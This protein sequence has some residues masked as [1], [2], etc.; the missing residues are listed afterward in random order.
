MRIKTV[1]LNLPEIPAIPDSPEVSN[2]LFTAVIV[3]TDTLPSDKRPFEPLPD[4]SDDT[5]VPG[6]FSQALGEFKLFYEEL[7]PTK[8]ITRIKRVQV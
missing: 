6:K 3:S 5:V 1:K 4:G 2:S 7:R 8:P